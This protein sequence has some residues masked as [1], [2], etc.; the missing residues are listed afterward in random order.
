[1]PV[2]FRQIDEGFDFVLKGETVEQQVARLKDWAST[3]ATIVPI[4]RIG[5]GAEKREWSLPE[6]LPEGGLKLEKDIPQGMG[7][8]TLTLEW[9]RVTQFITPGSNMNN[10]DKWKREQQW[11][12]ILES[13]HHNE[14]MLLT[15]V[16]DGKLLTLYP[17][18]EKLMKPLGITEYNAPQKE[19]VKRNTASKSKKKVKTIVE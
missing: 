13:I 10:L 3:N 1:M 5:V 16:K 7:P 14:A 17:G 15:A 8:S 11:I 19:V 6:G 2:K 4:V 12:N 18:L 9:R